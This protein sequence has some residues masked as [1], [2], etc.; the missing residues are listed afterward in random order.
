MGDFVWINNPKPNRFWKFGKMTSSI[1]GIF[2]M[3]IVLLVLN[4]RLSQTNADEL[5]KNA[6][7]VVAICTISLTLLSQVY[8]WWRDINR[9]WPHKIGFNDEEI[10]LEYPKSP[11]K[12]VKWKD[13][14]EVMIFRGKHIETMGG[15]ATKGGED[16]P[17][18]CE[19]AIEALYKKWNEIKWGKRL[20]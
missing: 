7:I 16:I 5:R 13:V 9:L 6:A 3:V 20:F 8:L 18:I 17:L 11:K 14:K 10:I 1:V 2:G 19:D 12:I 4:V 15:I